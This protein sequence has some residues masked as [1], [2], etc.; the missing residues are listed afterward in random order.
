LTKGFE[1]KK[2]K[3]TIDNEE[4][5][6]VVKRYKNVKKYMKSPLFAVKTMDGTED[7]VSKLIEEGET[8]P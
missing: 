8:Q 6:K 5:N 3:C 1:D 4:L 7:Y 2:V